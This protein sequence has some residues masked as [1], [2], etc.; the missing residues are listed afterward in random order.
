M[1]RL[2]NALGKSGQLLYFHVAG[3]SLDIND[4]AALKH[5][6]ITNK[7]LNG[8]NLKENTLS[9]DALRSLQPTLAGSQL[10]YLDLARTSMDVEGAQ[11]ISEVLVANPN[12]EKVYLEDNPLGNNGATLLLESA[13]TTKALQYLSLD[14]V[15]AGDCV[16]PPLLATMQERALSTGVLQGGQ[17]AT[18]LTVSL[19]GNNISTAALEHLASQLPRSLTDRIIC[20]MRIIQNGEIRMRSLSG[21]LCQLRAPRRYG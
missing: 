6:L 14:Y 10:R 19:H 17:Q 2:A 5:I 3:C 7:N 16:V 9:A 4:C 1:V 21:A 13:K 15:N 11:V 20:G 8:L 18:R 12:L